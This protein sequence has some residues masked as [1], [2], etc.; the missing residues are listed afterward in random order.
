MRFSDRRKQVHDMKQQSNQREGSRG[1]SGRRWTGWRRSTT[2]AG[3]LRA[4][5]LL[6]LLVALLALGAARPASAVWNCD[7]RGW[8]LNE[9]WSNTSNWN[10][11]DVPN[12]TDE[13]AVFKKDATAAL[14]GVFA[15]DELQLGWD[16]RDSGIDVTI[17]GQTD[18]SDPYADI[19]QLSVPIPG[20]S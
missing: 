9:N 15:F 11:D 12:Q 18:G 7:W 16:S 4:C 19:R 20:V 5:R 1:E 8:G 3:A 6:G 10:W 17:L 14:N 2:F 13:A